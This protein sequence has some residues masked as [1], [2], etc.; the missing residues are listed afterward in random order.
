MA[1]KTKIGV[2]EVKRIYALLDDGMS[3]LNIANEIGVSK[4][5]I[6]RIK[7][8]RPGN[9]QPKAVPPQ[10][11]KTR[12]PRLQTEI[13]VDMGV[14]GDTIRAIYLMLTT[15]SHRGKINECL[16]DIQTILSRLDYKPRIRKEAK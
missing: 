5:S 8:A 14:K 15:T 1:G 2:D 16:E 10:V 11:R 6:A 4:A 13:P 3:F 9:G 12:K 7:K